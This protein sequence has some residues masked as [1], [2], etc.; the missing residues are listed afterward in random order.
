MDRQVYTFAATISGRAVKPQFSDG[1]SLVVNSKIKY[2]KV[3]E[4]GDSFFCWW[5][6]LLVVVQNCQVMSLLFLPPFFPCGCW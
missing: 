4:V 3:R 1:A 5:L 2:Q 6:R